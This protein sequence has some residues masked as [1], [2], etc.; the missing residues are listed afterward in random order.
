MN[1]TFA[2][3]YASD[4][5]W[6]LRFVI[7]LVGDVHAAEDIVADTF[8][9]VHG[10]WQAGR[11]EHPHAYLRTTA[12]NLAANHLR[13]RDVVRRARLRLDADSRGRLA[14]EQEL[15]DRD[16]L[17]A[18]LRNLS[19]NQRITVVMRFYDQAPY[20]AIADQLGCSEVTVR[21]HL[22]RGLARLRD[23]LGPTADRMRA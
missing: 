12:A 15:C 23:Q 21:S 2:E 6:L 1:S 13:H 18:A 20:A 14:P 7:M 9:R 22:S 16:E 4:S 19:V 8:A 5:T 11:V 10:P 17:L 3:L